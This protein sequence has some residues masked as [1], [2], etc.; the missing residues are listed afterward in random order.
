MGY[1]LV[2]TAGNQSQV[3]EIRP[4]DS[5]ILSVI[6][7]IPANLPFN[8]SVVAGEARGCAAW[9]CVTTRFDLLFVSDPPAMSS[10]VLDQARYINSSVSLTATFVLPTALAAVVDQ[11]TLLEACVGTTQYG[12]QTFPFEALGAGN[13]SW[14]SPTLPQHCGAT[15]YVTMRATNCAGLQ[16]TV[17]SVGTKMCCEP[18]TAGSLQLLNSRGDAVSP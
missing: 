18:P 1:T 7:L 15:F 13:S 11:F 16:R 6:S 14:Q 17:A 3:G 5:S 10:V 9:S 4:L 2:L 12:C 8:G